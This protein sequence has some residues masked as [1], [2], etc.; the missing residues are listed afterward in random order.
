[1]DN[2]K[3]QRVCLKFCASNGISCSDALKM[4]QKAFGDSTISRSQAYDWYKAFEEG[5]ENVDDL[6]R[7]GRPPNSNEEKR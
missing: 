1:M 3:Q 4:L 6:P 2:N 7:S 5:R